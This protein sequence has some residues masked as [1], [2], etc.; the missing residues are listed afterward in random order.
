MTRLLVSS[1]GDALSIGGAALTNENPV[2]P[3]LSSGL[4][5]TVTDLGFLDA[6]SNRLI[7]PA[8]NC[9]VYSVTVGGVEY[10]V[11]WE[12]GYVDV[13][14][15]FN[16]CDYTMTVYQWGTCDITYN[17]AHVANLPADDT[18]EVVA[19]ITSYRLAWYK[20]HVLSSAYGSVDITV[21]GESTGG[22]GDT[23]PPTVSFAAPS[24]FNE[25]LDQDTV[26]TCSENVQVGTGNFYKYNATT[27]VLIETVAAA[28][29]NYS[30]STVTIPWAVAETNST[31]YSVR[32]DA[33][34]FEDLAGNGVAA[35]TDDTFAYTTVASVVSS[36]DLSPDATVSSIAAVQS[37][38]D[39]WESNWNSTTPSGK[40][41]SDHRVVGLD[42]S[43]TGAL[44]LNNYVFPQN[45]YVRHVGTFS[46]DADGIASISV[47]HTGTGTLNNCTKLW[48]TLMDIRAPSNAD[49]NNGIWS[50]DGTADCGVYRCALKGWPFTINTS[51]SGTTSYFFVGTGSTRF[52]YKYNVGYYFADGHFKI[53]G[54]HTDFLLEGNMGN[55]FGGDDYTFANGVR[56]VDPV[57]RCNFFARNRMMKPGNH[58]DGIQFNKNPSGSGFPCTRWFSEYDIFLRGVW[59]GGAIANP[60]ESGWGAYWTKDSTLACQGPHLHQHCLFVNGHNRAITGFTGGGTTAN[61]ISAI[62]HD[63]DQQ[64]NAAYP[65]IRNVQTATANLCCGHNGGYTT[66]IGTGGLLL[67]LGGSVDGTGADYTKLLPYCTNIPTNY[68]DL[69][70]MRPPSGART[71]PDYTPSGDRLGC[72]GLWQK[73]F[74]GDADIVLSKVGW[75][76]AKLFVEDFDRSDNFW[77]GFNN[78]YDSNGEN[79]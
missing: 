78:T 25:A 46:A 77:G 18:A 36:L 30:G 31:A 22:V 79:T 10:F 34:T 62:Q 8:D 72:W 16:S 38:L 57:S 33:G 61:Y 39:D 45:V 13:T 65:Y 4:E 12:V 24:G 63:S 37:Q 41:N 48:L 55:Y 2:F 14:F 64:P 56:M 29:A 17:P 54:T 19:T 67:V 49:F 3:A 42:T 58:N 9:L 1:G 32:W 70:D 73:L 35:R 52:T 21:N 28:S 74:N 51:A 7:Q 23:V 26:L 69:W 5:W 6:V 75:P 59:G 44:N 27:G 60:D 15:T 71:H 68:T 50:I 53:F 47:N 11:D 43:T 20:A 76:V 66:A 40:T